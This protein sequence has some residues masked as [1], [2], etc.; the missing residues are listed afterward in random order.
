[1]RLGNADFK[2]ILFLIHFDQVKKDT[3]RKHMPAKVPKKHIDFIKLKATSYMKY[4]IVWCSHIET[5][6]AKFK[7]K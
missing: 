3:A 5:G 4:L 2:D 6:V 7:R 1:M